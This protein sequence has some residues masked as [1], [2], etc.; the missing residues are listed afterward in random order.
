MAL[1][2]RPHGV[3]KENTQDILNQISHNCEVPSQQIGKRPETMNSAKPENNISNQSGDPT[4]YSG[5]TNINKADNL[6]AS[7][8]NQKK[9]PQVERNAEHHQPVQFVKQEC[10]N[11]NA[12]DAIDEPKSN[13]E[14][15]S[16]NG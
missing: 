8:N 16:D 3:N 11:E 4:I 14:K 15:I 12:Y 9:D 1:N 2:I 6:L 5:V 13:D 10:A 7:V